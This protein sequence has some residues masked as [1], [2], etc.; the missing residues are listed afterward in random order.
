MRYYAPDEND[1]L[2][3]WADHLPT[4]TFSPSPLRALSPTCPIPHPPCSYFMPFISFM[5]LLSYVYVFL[6]HFTFSRVHVFPARVDLAPFFSRPQQ[7]VVPTHNYIQISR[8]YSTPTSVPLRLTPSH[9][10]P[11]PYKQQQQQQQQQQQHT[12]THT[13]VYTKKTPTALRSK[14]RLIIVKN[15]EYEKLLI[16]TLAMKHKLYMPL[17]LTNTSTW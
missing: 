7:R 14:Y 12:H 13:H 4:V 2:F 16:M 6:F 11:I 15:H 5:L 3:Q 10:V 8:L 9:T 17:L 1:G